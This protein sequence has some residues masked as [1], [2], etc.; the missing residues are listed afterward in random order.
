MPLS[1]RL[2]SFKSYTY[3][4][5]SDAKE[6]FVDGKNYL[7]K[8]V[9]SLKNISTKTVLDLA[10]K[11]KNCILNNYKATFFVIALLFAFEYAPM[12][13]LAASCVTLIVQKI[14]FEKEK[15]VVSINNFSLAILGAIG[16]ILEIA[17]CPVCDP[18]FYLAPMMSGAA[19]ARASFNLYQNYYT[20]D[21]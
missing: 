20:K 6:H 12:R 15:E 18:S 17:F 14:D 1:I 2:D 13:F 5:Y 11:T 8:K 21:S 9:D 4:K 3:K 16:I 19:F 10:K 7:G